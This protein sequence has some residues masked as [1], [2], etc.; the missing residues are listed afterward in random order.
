MNANGN[1]TNAIPE[2]LDIRHELHSHPELGLFGVS[3][4]RIPRRQTGGAKAIRSPRALPPPAIVATLK[5]GTSTRTIGIR[6]DIDALPIHEET[7]LP[8]ASKTPGLMHACGHDGHT[9]M[10]LLLPAPSPNARI[11]TAPCI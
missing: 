5:N 9:T 3:H 10:L 2:L 11:S 8:Y 1:L 7:G 4:L 6:A